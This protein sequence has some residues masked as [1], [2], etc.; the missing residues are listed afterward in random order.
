MAQINVLVQVKGSTPWP[1][2]TILSLYACTV[3]RKDMADEKYLEFLLL[4]RSCFFTPDIRRPNCTHLSFQ[5]NRRRRRY[6][7]SINVSMLACNFVVRRCWTLACTDQWFQVA[8]TAFTSEEWCDNFRVFIWMNCL[9]DRRRNWS[10]RYVNAQF[11]FSTVNCLH[12]AFY[13]T[14]VRFS[15]TRTNFIRARRSEHG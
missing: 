1:A 2:Y 10:S 12:L 7:L 4:K 14:W 8:E 11:W 6:K 5:K 3:L 15:G 13:R 9:T